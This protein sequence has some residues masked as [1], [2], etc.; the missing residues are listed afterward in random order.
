MGRGEKTRWKMTA[1]SRHLPDT[2]ESQLLRH[3]VDG[4]GV[5]EAI[6]ESR[7]PPGDLRP[8]FHLRDTVIHSSPA[9]P[10]VPASTVMERIYATLREPGG[11]SAGDSRHG[12]PRSQVSASGRGGCRTLHGFFFDLALTAYDFSTFAVSVPQDSNCGAVSAWSE[13][14][15]VLSDLFPLMCLTYVVRTVFLLACPRSCSGCCWPGSPG[16]ILAE[17]AW[18]GIRLDTVP[19]LVFVD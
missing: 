9:L 16:S 2:P 10:S 8:W 17:A 6:T 11:L 13:P 18:S 7:P 3:V 4:F 5:V 14:L 19:A 15:H 12:I 1:P